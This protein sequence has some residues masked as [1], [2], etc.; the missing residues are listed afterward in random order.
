MSDLTVEPERIDLPPGAFYKSRR[1][2]VRW[3]GRTVIG[4]SQ[5]AFRAY[6]FPVCTPSGIPLTEESPVDHP[7]HNSVWI[8]ADHVDCQLPYAD[9]QQETANY[10][11][12]VQETFQGR[13]AGRMIAH[14]VDWQELGPEH[15]RVVQDIEW[16]G[17]AE[18]GAPGGRSIVRESR[19]IDVQ[20]GEAAHTIDIRS[21]LRPC[22]GDL[23]LGPTRHAYF[24][25]RLIEALRPSGGGTLIDAQRRRGVSAVDGA[26]SDWVHVCGEVIRNQVAG[27]ACFPCGHTGSGPWRVHPWGTIDVNPLQSQPRALRVGEQLE[28][29]IRLV[30]HDEPRDATQIAALHQ[31][32]Q[33]RTLADWQDLATAGDAA[34]PSRGGGSL[35]HG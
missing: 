26:R 32:F 33:E 30:V 12:Y 28:Y 34:A 18:W 8:G 15:L 24:G 6:L 31:A 21:R 4:L 5:N 10:N 20:P 29:G 9:H 17:P 16:R 1:H 35:D 13:A 22:S 11:F 19:A 25:I 23:Q 14:A 27:L 3:R 7:H 2:Y